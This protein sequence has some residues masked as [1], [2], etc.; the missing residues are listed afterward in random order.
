MNI[1]NQKGVNMITLSIAVIIL[2]MI[3]SVL[4]YNAKDGA[5][6]KTLSN[7][8]NDIEQLNNKVS[9]YY[10]KN[11][12]IPKGPK[13]VNPDFLSS[14]P[15]NQINPNN[16]S[17]FYVI[18]LRA[19]EGITLN[20]GR[21]YSEILP[22][23]TTVLA[24]EDIYVINEGSHTIYYVKGIEVQG[25]RYYTKIENWTNIDLSVIPIYTAQQLSWVGDGTQHAVN[26][27][28]Y[29][30]ALNGIYSLQNNIDLSSVCS[31][32]LG[33]SWTPIGATSQFA[34]TFYGNKHEVKNLYISNSTSGAQVGLFK[35][36]SNCTIKDVGVSGSI[37]TSVQAECGGIAGFVA[38]GKTANIIN[39]YSKTNITSAV[40]SYS[41]GGIVGD[42]SGT[43]N[44][45]NCYNEGKITGG[46]NNGGITGY[47][48]GTLNLQNCYN[49]GEIVNNLGANAG[50]LLGRDNAASNNTTINKCYNDGKVTGK[51]YVG[52][53]FGN[54]TG[55]SNITN[56]YNDNEVSS[57]NAGGTGGIIG[58]AAANSTPRV[59]NCYNS[60]YVKTA[61][62]YLGGIIGRIVSTSGMIEEC[63][64]TGKIECNQTSG[65]SSYV[66]GIAGQNAGTVTK[67]YNKGPITSTK[68]CTGGIAGTN[69]GGLISLCYNN[70]T[71]DSEGSS[72]TG[73]IAGYHSA[74]NSRIINCFN[75]KQVTG[76]GSVG[77]II[78]NHQNGEIANC[79]NLGKVQGTS[80]Y[81]SV[82]GSKGTNGSVTNCYYLSTLSTTDSNAT[83]ETEAN[84]K[85][86]AFVTTLN[87]SQT[88][89]P[90]KLDTGI[91]NGFPIFTWM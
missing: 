42:N 34:G 75:I 88:D 6:I 56:S 73:G 25:T 57:T 91:N 72:G 13:Y 26:G 79:Y 43:A 68:N 59:T 82:V 37:Y 35:A 31:E 63:Y 80:N 89:T 19:L 86:Q 81:K 90:W 32:T 54:N 65:T 16:G 14:V 15:S 11:E 84:M 60:G 2:I 77:G 70:G 18:D 52:G 51:T 12:E 87:A 49:I 29:T 83:A 9:T 53:L 8:Y 44:I 27:V 76:K 36:L 85:L 28:N 4:V 55:I 61:G 21:D 48:N 69:P 7:L 40:G 10:I 24:L 71:V 64:N 66:G 41:S 23:D 17:D 38:S 45:T 22:T 30:F 1:R 39:C 47:T 33:V 67:S 5:K 78:G 3:T 20:Y 62:Y 46:N 58:I 74:E 50:G